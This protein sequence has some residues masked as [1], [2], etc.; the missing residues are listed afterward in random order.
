VVQG[1]A[2]GI[3]IAQHLAPTAALRLSLGVAVVFYLLTSLWVIGRAATLRVRPVWVIGAARSAIAIGLLAG[4]AAALGISILARLAAGHTVVD[5]FAGLLV[6]ASPGAFVIGAIVIA[7]VAPVVEEFIFRGFLAEAF[8]AR[9][10]RAAIILSA[11]AFSVAHLRFAQFRYY[12]LMGIALGFIYW[13]SGLAG[14]ISA[15]AAFNGTLVVLALVAAHG[16][17]VTMRADGYALRLPATWHQMPTTGPVDLAAVGPNGAQFQLSH[18][19]FPQGRAVALDRIA[20]ALRA[21]QLPLPRNASLDPSSVQIVQLP[22]GPA[23]RLRAT[24]NGHREESA[25]MVTGTRLLA[26]DLRADGSTQAERDFQALLATAAV[27]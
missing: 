22:I 11:M 15:H 25:L 24:V 2:L 3:T 9:G 26:F 7:G 14:S 12:V 21:G 1:F 27:G 17:P 19:D 18:F 5:P 23:I 10:S 4:A 13:R 8:R 20:G 16:P 6:D